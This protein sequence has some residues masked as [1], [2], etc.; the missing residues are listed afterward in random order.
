MEFRMTRRLL[1]LTVAAAIAA[2]GGGSG[3]AVPDGGDSCAG[4]RCSELDSG[5]LEDAA[6]DADVGPPD[7][8]A[9][10]P[11]ACAIGTPCNAAR[12]CARGECIAETTGG[13]GD[14]SDPIVGHPEGSTT[15]AVTTW[16]DGYCTAVLPSETSPFACDPDLASDPVCGD[17]GTCVAVGGIQS[18]CFQSCA[19]SVEDRD[20]CRD[21]YE[22][23]LNAEVCFPGCTGDDECRLNRVET[24]GIAGIQA[25]DD[26]AGDATRAPAEQVCGGVDT[27]FDALTYDSE[28]TATC[29]A[30]TSRCRHGGSAGASGGDGCTRDEACEADGV[31]LTEA[32]FDWPD[33][34]CTKFRCDLVGN[35]CAGDAVCQDRRLGVF[36]CLEGCTVAGGADPEDETTW[37]GDRGGCREGYGCIW[38]GVDGAGVADNGAC[39]PGEFNDV[40]ANNIGDAC[41][42]DSD[43]WS[44]F[45][46]G[47]CL[48]ANDDGSGFRGGYCSV[49]DCLAPGVPASL[50]GAA[51]QCLDLDGADGDVTGCLADCATVDDCREG[52]ECTD[53]DGDPATVGGVCVPA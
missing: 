3:D 14:A 39:V 27:A 36:L 51:S 35:A 7:A 11:T 48:S 16:R 9:D 4:D 8:D 5:P 52:Y 22:C 1:V 44:P 45:G 49:L 25:P 29:D 10:A 38:N 2:C 47:L 33:G 53:V 34:A 17:C 41:D 21:G 26:C 19:P 43:C 42:D 46:Q 12:G 30:A 28:S 18:L 24:N 40:G 31:C 50:C 15:V 32:G 13:I 6:L 37:L 20:L 23:S